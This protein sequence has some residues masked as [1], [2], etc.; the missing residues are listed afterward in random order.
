MKERE[1]KNGII[2]GEE[3]NVKIEE[4]LFR[5]VDIDLR[6]FKGDYGFR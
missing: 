1:N 3:K 5:L 6:I 2:E 4:K